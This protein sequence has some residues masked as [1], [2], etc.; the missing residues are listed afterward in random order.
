MRQC[1]NPDCKVVDEIGY[2]AC[3]KCGWSLLE[4]KVEKEE[5]AST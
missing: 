1:S 2:A 3:P 5:E 4:V